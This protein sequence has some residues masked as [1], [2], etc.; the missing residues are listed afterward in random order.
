MNVIDS[1]KQVQDIVTK[2]GPRGGPQVIANS[3]TVL[4]V[5]VLRGKWSWFIFF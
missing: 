2:P 4:G 5:S 3:N 1:F